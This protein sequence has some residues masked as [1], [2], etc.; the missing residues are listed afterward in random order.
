[1]IGNIV[2]AAD[3]AAL[4]SAVISLMVDYRTQNTLTSLFMYLFIFTGLFSVIAGIVC[5]RFY[6]KALESRPVSSGG[7]ESITGLPHI[8]ELK[9]TAWFF[10]GFVPLLFFTAF[11]FPAIK[12]KNKI[13]WGYAAV[14]GAAVILFL[15]QVGLMS[16]FG[17]IMLLVLFMSHFFSLSL[18]M[19]IRAK[20][21]KFIADKEMHSSMASLLKS[22][23]AVSGEPKSEDKAPAFDTKPDSSSSAPAPSESSRPLININTCTEEE[24]IAL[25]GLNII[26]AKKTISLR[27]QNGDFGSIEEFITALHIKPHIAAPLYDYITAQPSFKAAPKTTARTRKIDL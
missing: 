9:R 14:F 11:I 22:E 7:I 23:K 26:D 15:T 25:P 13:Y 20:Y 6:W 19:N 17:E 5:L 3:M 16:E 18:L 10:I 8:W 4:M 24:L 12:M 21:L 1:T 27:E 2:L